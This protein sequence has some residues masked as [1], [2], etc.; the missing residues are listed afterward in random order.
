MRQHLSKCIEEKWG[1]QVVFEKDTLQALLM[2]KLKKPEFRLQAA[3]HHSE[4]HGAQDTLDLVDLIDRE[5][6]LRY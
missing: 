4:R 6:S 2:E 5:W 1:K 3:I